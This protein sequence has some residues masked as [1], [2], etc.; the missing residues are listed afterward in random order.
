VALLA[1]MRALVDDGLRFE[2]AGALGLLKRTQR[3]LPYVIRFN[4]DRMGNLVY[5]KFLADPRSESEE[6]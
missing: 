5:V 4:I 2:I 6:V 1:G 3:E